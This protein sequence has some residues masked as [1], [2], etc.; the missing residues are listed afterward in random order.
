MDSFTLSN[1][2]LYQKYG[3]LSSII[4]LIIFIWSITWKGIA[5]WHAS[6]KNEKIWFIA[7]LVINTMGILEIIYLYYLSKNK[8]TAKETLIFI[9]TL[10]IKKLK[11]LLTS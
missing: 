2:A 10:N 3:P 6:Q 9:R 5:L 8:F 4:V 7:L 11:V 1:F